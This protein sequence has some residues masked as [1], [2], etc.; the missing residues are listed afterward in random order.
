MVLS[1]KKSDRTMVLS[2]FFDD[3]TMVLLK[4]KNPTRL[5]TPWRKNRVIDFCAMVLLSNIYVYLF[6]TYIYLFY[7]TL[8][9]LENPLR[10]HISELKVLFKAYYDKT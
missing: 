8:Q 3:N 2:N 6:I 5:T 10:Y 4:F 1:P 7:N 9:R